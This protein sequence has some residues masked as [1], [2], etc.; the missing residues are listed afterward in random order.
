MRTLCLVAAALALT[1]SASFAGE[2]ASA[3]GL[4]WSQGGA[5]L[6][7]VDPISRVQLPQ[8]RRG[9]PR[10]TRTTRCRR[11]PTAHSSRARAAWTA[12]CTSARSA[13]SAAR[14]RSGRCRAAS[15]RRSGSAAARSRS[16][17]ARR[18]R[19]STSG[20]A[21][22]GRRSRSA[23]RSSP[24]PR[25]AGATSRSWRRGTAS[26]PSSSSR[27]RAS[28]AV[29]TLAVPGLRGGRE[30]QA[31]PDVPCARS[32]VSRSRPAARSR[33]SC[34]AGTASSPRTS[35]RGRA[36]VIVVRA[37]RTLQAAAKGLAGWQ[38]TSA[39]AGSGTLVT[40]GGDLTGDEYA[41]F[42]GGTPAG[43][44]IT[45]LGT[46][47]THLA[48]P[49]A[50]QFRICGG[51]IVAAGA[52]PAVGSAGVVALDRKGRPRWSQYDGAGVMLAGCT[53]RLRLPLDARIRVRDARHPHGRGA[54]RAPRLGR[55]GHR[56]D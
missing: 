15:G 26:A 18:S 28:G 51:L 52:K 23:A 40:T 25:P 32:R 46:R 49:G 33:T 8:A 3:P 13:R 10:A 50:N 47:R 38:R 19:S 37:G 29:R 9:A 54:R 22:R 48:V 56:G 31:G 35:P 21:G 36:R 17:R 12:T 53:A 6:T 39:V 55:D 14:G 4:I 11:R 24:R 43:L 5:V 30:L 44:R 2:T 1:A 41:S 7:R 27:V 16:V 20:R 42:L 34:R 45:D